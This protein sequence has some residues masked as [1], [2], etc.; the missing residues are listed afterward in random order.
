MLQMLHSDVRAFEL[1][2]NETQQMPAIGVPRVNRDELFTK[3]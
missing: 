3:R 2:L 1:L